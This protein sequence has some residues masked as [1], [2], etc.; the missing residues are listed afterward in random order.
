MARLLAGYG[1]DVRTAD[2]VAAALA[3]AAAHPF[4]VVVSDIGLPDA[5]GYDL[6]RHLQARHGLRGIALSGYGM[7]DDVRKSRDAGFAEHLVKPI[8]I[9]QLQAALRRVLDAPLS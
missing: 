8:D 5:S 4:D 2:S 1:F 3:L 7:E 9:T 6:I